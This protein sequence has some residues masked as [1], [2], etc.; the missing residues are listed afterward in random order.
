MIPD[1]GPAGVMTTARRKRKSAKHGRPR[2]VIDADQHA[3]REGGAWPS[4]ES[5][6][7]IVPWKP[8]NAGGGKGP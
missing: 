7:P 4:G 3:T 6:R 5:E 2:L 1:D 8:G